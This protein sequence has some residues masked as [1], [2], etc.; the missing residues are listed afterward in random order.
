MYQLHHQIMSWKSGDSIIEQIIRP[1]GLID[2]TI[3]IKSSK[4]QI[5]DLLMKTE[6]L[7]KKKKYL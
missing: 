3:Q 6:E 2:P 5:D 4:N 7:I 1:T